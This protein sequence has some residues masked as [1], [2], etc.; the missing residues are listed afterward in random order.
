VAKSTIQQL[1]EEISASKPM[2]EKQTMDLLRRPR[3][4]G[5]EVFTKKKS[6]TC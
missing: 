1:K 4:P 5:G 6:L 3:I 2:T